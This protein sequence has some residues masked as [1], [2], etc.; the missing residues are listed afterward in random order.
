MDW[1]YLKRE[2]KSAL[3][4]NHNHWKMSGACKVPKIQ[5]QDFREECKTYFSLWVLTFPTHRE[6]TS[7]KKVRQDQPE[8]MRKKFCWYGELPARLL[9]LMSTYPDGTVHNPPR[10]L[11]F[12]NILLGYIFKPSSINQTSFL[13]TFF[14]RELLNFSSL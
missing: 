14:S 5:K 1:L 9:T 4:Q 8:K 12:S 13:N 10:F 6:I 11:R 2:I 3:W 7:E